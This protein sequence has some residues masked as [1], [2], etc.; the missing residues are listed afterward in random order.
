MDALFFFRHSVDDDFEIRHALRGIACHMPWVRKVWV[1]GDEPR[2]LSDNRSIIEHVPHEYVARAGKFRT[3]ITNFFLMFYLSS[4]IPEMDEEYIWFCDDFFPI[5]DLTIE[6]ARKDRYIVDMDRA[7]RAKGLWN[8]SLWRTYDFLRRLGYSRYNFEIHAPTFF[9]KKR[10]HEAYCDLKDFVTQ[11]R[12]FGLLGPTAILNHAV[13][14]GK[15]DLVHRET[16]GRWLGYYQ[17][18]PA[19]DTIAAQAKGKSFFN[20]DDA[21]LTADVRRF[22]RERF[23]SPSKYERR[24]SDPPG[25]PYTSPK[26][27]ADTLR[28]SSPTLSEV[29]SLPRFLNDEKLVGTAVV[30]VSATP[31]FPQLMLADWQGERLWLV[32]ESVNSPEFDVDETSQWQVIAKDPSV[33]ANEFDEGC[34]DFLYLESKNESGDLRNIL[35]SWFPKIRSGGMLAGSNYLTCSLPACTIDVKTVVDQWCWEK[36]LRVECT[37][38]GFFRSWMTRKV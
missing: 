14:A 36:S 28:Y 20:C 17:R 38:E 3:P 9:T 8:D 37:G 24:V 34:V 25:K 1:F 5:G 6:D 2:F 13:N 11:D 7:T 19:Y 32:T 35:E 12:W 10:V 18:A 16:E 33:A 4:L 31:T 23:P 27:P 15:S 21:S 30:V 22:L 26:T 29:K